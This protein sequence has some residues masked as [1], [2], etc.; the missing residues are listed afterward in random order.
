MKARGTVS[1]V[2]PMARAREEAIGQLASAVVDRIDEDGTVF[3]AISDAP[4]ERARIAA[5]PGLALVAGT[6]VLVLIEREGPVIV[7]T[8]LSR[9]AEPPPTIE[10][11]AQEQIVLRVGDATISI[12]AQGTVAIRGERIDSEAEGI[13]RIKGAQVRIN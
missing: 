11:Q 5:A 6:A 12:D 4:P 8:I 13:Q 2:L 7:S 10:L 3:V 1:K 9:L